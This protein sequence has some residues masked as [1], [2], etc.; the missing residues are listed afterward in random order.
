MGSDSTAA[1]PEPQRTWEEAVP[2]QRWVGVGGRVGQW[3]L[4]SFLPSLLC[5]LHS[6]ERKGGAYSVFGMKLWF[7]GAS[8][9]SGKL[10][11]SDPP[12]PVSQ[13]LSG[14]RCDSRG[15]PDPQA[16][17]G[18]RLRFWAHPWNLPTDQVPDGV[19]ASPFLPAARCSCS[20][21]LPI[22]VACL[23]LSH[24]PPS[25]TRETLAR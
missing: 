22:S 1:C 12:L 16:S 25:P 21:L 24:W 5:C 19:V 17:P 7:L 8:L 20:S 15:P 13:A 4:G 14:S 10:Q 6:Q 2:D 11:V 9:L 23:P 18:V 3:A